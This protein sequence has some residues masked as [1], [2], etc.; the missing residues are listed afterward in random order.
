MAW[1]SQWTRSLLWQLRERDLEVERVCAL[2]DLKLRE[3]DDL[4]RRNEAAK[5]NVYEL[6]ETL[7]S[8]QEVLASKEMELA[9]VIVYA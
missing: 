7:V 2:N 4:E 6:E 8:L 9:E 3:I 5:T 1:R